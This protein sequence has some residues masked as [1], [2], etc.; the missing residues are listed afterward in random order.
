MLTREDGRYLDQEL[1]LASHTYR[2][3]SV[4]SVVTHHAFPG[5]DVA[6]DIGQANL[7]STTVGNIFI[8]HGHD[9]HIGGLGSHHLRRNG[10]GLDPARYYVQEDDVPLVKALV[11]AQCHLNRSK[12]LAHVDVVPVGEGSEFETK[13]G[14]FV[15]PF[16]STHKIPCMGYALWSQRKR[17]RADLQGAPKEAI[18]AAKNRGEEINEHFEVPEVAFPGDTNLLILKRPAGEIIR[19]ARV[20]LLECTFIDDEVSPKDTFRTGHIHLDD[21]IQAARDGVFQNEVIVLTH[22][23][24]RY[25][26]KY[27]RQVVTQRLRNEDIWPRVHLLLPP[28]KKI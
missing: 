9:D 26:T 15:R 1:T 14:L 27:I 28:E 12:A 25:T 22:F 13:S 6:F 10:W 11:E 16:R 17:L 5:H 23:S 18:L 20:L 21:F 4:G 19:K 7:A 8:T 24:A 3:R 2:G